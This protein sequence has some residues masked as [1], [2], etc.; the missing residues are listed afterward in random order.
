MGFDV[1]GVYNGFFDGD[2]AFDDIPALLDD[3]LLTMVN[4][5]L[6]SKSSATHRF[7][8]TYLLP[9]KLHLS[10]SSAVV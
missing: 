1:C 7:P 2:C 5:V 8:G 3:S 9:A 4:L 6:V 10:I